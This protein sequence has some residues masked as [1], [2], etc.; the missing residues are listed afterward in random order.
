MSVLQGRM[1]EQIM[2]NE[3]MLLMAYVDE[4]KVEKKNIWFH[5]SRSPFLS[6]CTQE[7]PIIRIL[8]ISTPSNC[9]INTNQSPQLV[10]PF[11]TGPRPSQQPQ[12]HYN[13]EAFS[14]LPPLTLPHQ[15]CK[16]L[17]QEKGGAF[18]FLLWPG[19]EKKREQVT[20]GNEGRSE[21]RPKNS[22]STPVKEERT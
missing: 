22:C 7:S 12:F 14:P 13:Q 20:E 2:Q 6:G 10:S 18:F 11:S 5:D 3:E 1:T 15:S 8:S 19:K 17:F 21:K 4:K 9:P 16:H